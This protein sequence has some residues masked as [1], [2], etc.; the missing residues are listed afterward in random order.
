MIINTRFNVIESVRMDVR[1]AVLEMARMRQHFAFADLSSLDI[2]VV[3]E[4]MAGKRDL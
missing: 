4:I 3:W 2:N 1:E